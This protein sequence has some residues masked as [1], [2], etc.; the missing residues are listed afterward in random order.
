MDGLSTILNSA[1]Q[2]GASIGGKIIN[3]MMYAD[4]ICVLSLS[5]AG[6]Q[7]LLDICNEYCT[8]HDLV[9]NVK[10]SQCMFF[11]CS[12]NKKCGLPT[13]SLNSNRIEFTHEV[14]Y[15]GV[16]LSSCMKTTIDVSRQTR[17][18]YMQ[19]NLML[20]NFRYCTDQVKCTLFQS[21]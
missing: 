7:Q 18:F 12:I 17:K 11:R 8:N 2:L 14:K 13:I 20:R 6:L 10:K 15:L 3:H 4:D 19:S 1:K 21:Y 5:S 9:F 16:L